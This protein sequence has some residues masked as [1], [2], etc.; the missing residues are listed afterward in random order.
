[1]A[2]QKI[3]ILS[4]TFKASGAVGENRAIGFNGAQA[5]T[6]GQKVMGVSPRPVADGSYSEADVAGTTLIQAGGN[7]TKGASLIVNNQGKAIA[8]TG[9][10]AIKA[11]ATAMTSTAAN[12]STILQ[13]SDLPEYIFADALEDATTD[14]VVEVLLRR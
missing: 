14:D 7:F 6:Q 8:A 13:G 9:S 3:S 11:G 12:G 5:T 4:L 10:L 1:M 2:R